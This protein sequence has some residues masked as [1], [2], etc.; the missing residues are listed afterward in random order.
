MSTGRFYTLYLASIPTSL[1]IF[2]EKNKKG[3]AF[4]KY[5]TIEKL[6]KKQKLIK[7]HSLDEGD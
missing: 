2:L 4:L 7:L 5:R 6:K 3:K 1:G